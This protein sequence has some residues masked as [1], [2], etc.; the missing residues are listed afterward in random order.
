[1]YVNGYIKLDG[2]ILIMKINK[3]FAMAA[4]TVLCGAMFVGCGASSSSSSSRYAISRT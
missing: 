4:S 2:G 3:I 1:M